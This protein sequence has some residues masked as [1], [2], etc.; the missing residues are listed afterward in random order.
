MSL[1]CRRNCKRPLTHH[2]FA[3]GD[4]GALIDPTHR[5]YPFSAAGGRMRQESAH[6]TSPYLNAALRYYKCVRAL[7]AMRCAWRARRVSNRMFYAARRGSAAVAAHRAAHSPPDAV[8]APARSF[9][10]T[11]PAAL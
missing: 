11:A 6:P 8:R 1:K 4:K 10:S 9:T 2:R 3:P 5:S 7:A